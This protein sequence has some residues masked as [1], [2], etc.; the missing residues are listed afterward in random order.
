MKDGDDKIGSA[1]LHFSMKRKS[2]DLEALDRFVVASNGIWLLGGLPPK[3]VPINPAGGPAPSQATLLQAQQKLANEL[4]PFKNTQSLV[5]ISLSSDHLT[6]FARRLVADPL[7]IAV[8][9]KKSEG[10]IATAT[11]VK[12]NVLGNIGYFVTPSGASFLQGR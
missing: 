6:S 3:A 8:T 9:T 4:M 1:T 12:D 10:K 11:P 5:E 2:Q 7:Q